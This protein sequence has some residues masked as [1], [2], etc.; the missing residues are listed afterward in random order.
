MTFTEQERQQSMTYANNGAMFM[1]RAGEKL[2]QEASQDALTVQGMSVYI[3]TMLMTR[4][5]INIDSE[6]V[7]KYCN[8]TLDRKN[9]YVFDC[10]DIKVIPEPWDPIKIS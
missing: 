9:K 7:I 8:N 1:Y 10:G 2:A 3:K 4:E 6:M 5:W